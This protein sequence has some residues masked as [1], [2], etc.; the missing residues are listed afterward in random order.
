M[1]TPVLPK[2]ACPIEE[3]TET[4]IAALRAMPFKTIVSQTGKVRLS[5]FVTATAVVGYV[6]AGGTSP[7]VAVAVTAGTMLQSMSAN[8]ANQIIEVEHDKNMKRTCKRPLPVGAITPMGAAALSTAEFA[9]GTGILAA[10]SPLAAALGALNW[11]IYVCMYTPL[12]RVS[13]TNTWFGSIVGGIPPWMGGAAATGS[14][15]CAAMHP[16]TLL[17]AFMLVW[18]IP[19]FMA[20]SFHCRRDYEGAGYKM[21]AFANPWRASFYA[22][23]LS[24]IMAAISLVGPY[25]ID[26][27]VEGLWF[28]P[29]SVAANATMIYKSVRFHLDPVRNCRSCFVFSYMYLG[30]ML[31]A[32]TVNHFQPVG[33]ATKVVNALLAGTEAEKEVAAGAASS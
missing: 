1:G 5:G 15:T 20:L 26:M 29:I 30:V 14:L 27:P 23:L 8:T 32:F 33:I 18:Q 25:T 13:A 22:I 4:D 11:A 3:D 17:A 12:K 16:A 21:L 10:V 7:L 31:L 28:Y 24:V 2:M 9:V 19:H 6:M